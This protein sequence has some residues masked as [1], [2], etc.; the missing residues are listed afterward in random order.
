H[1]RGRRRRGA[2]TPG[3]G[4]RRRGRRRRGGGRGGVRTPLAAAVATLGRGAGGG[5][6]GGG[7]GGRRWDCGGDLAGPG[8]VDRVDGQDLEV[9]GVA[10]RPDLGVGGAVGQDEVG[11]HRAAALGREVVV[12]PQLP[13]VAPDAVGPGQAD[14]DGGRLAARP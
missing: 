7:G 9:A 3:R 1:G 8:A 4:R 10:G 12:G 6:G 11:H 13:P 2:R 5:R 14:G